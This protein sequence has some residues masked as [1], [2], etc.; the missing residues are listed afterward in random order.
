MAS[1]LFDCAEPWKVN[2]REFM[3]RYY[4][5]DLDL[6][7]FAHY[8]GRSLSAFKK[9]FEQQFQ[10]S[11]MKWIVRR[12]LDEAKRLIEQEKEVLL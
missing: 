11:P 2:L 1:I 4:A 9:D 7:G 10:T 8:T 3:S 6:Q 12:R 5:S